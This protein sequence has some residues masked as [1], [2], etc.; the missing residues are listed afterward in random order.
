MFFCRSLLFVCL[1]YFL[2]DSVGASNIASRLVGRTSR[3]V[4]RFTQDFNVA[5]GVVL[6]SREKLLP[7]VHLTNSQSVFCKSDAGA[8]SAGSNSSSSSLGPSGSSE[9]AGSSTNTASAAGSTSTGVAVSTPYKLVEEHSGSDFFDGWT[10]TDAADVTTH[11]IVDYVD[12]G[13]ASANNLTAITSDGTAI[14]RVET[15]ATVTGNR[16]SIRITTNSIYNS[17]LWILDAIHMPTGCGTWPAFWTNGP[18][19][20]DGGEIDIVEGVG[21]NTNDQ[22]T[23]HTLEGC[24]LA[25][26]SSSTLDITGSV[27]TSTDCVST[28]GGCG[29][30]ASSTV[31]Y[32]AAFNSNG[33]GVFTMTLN[34]SGI[35]VWFFERS[36]IPSDITAGTPL[37]GL[38][39]TPFAWWASPTCNIT[40]FFG[41]QSTIFDTTLC[42]DLAGSVWSDAGAPGQEQSCAT[43]TGVS[44]CDTFVRNNGASFQEAYW[45]LNSVK[46]YQIPS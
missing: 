35:A 42:G 18:N 10:F 40:E 6:D 27:I 29:I 32:G 28:G 46:I 13:T 5:L 17:G 30:R 25:S 36:N 3:Q 19:W 20:P 31:S 24:S 45:E 41:Y 4:R 39:G 11:G 1:S 14:M 12:E 38:W 26:S 22:A 7:Q 44:D 2:F 8:T 9:S 15:T 21:D 23:L 43:R 34:S 33:G 16:Q 37:P